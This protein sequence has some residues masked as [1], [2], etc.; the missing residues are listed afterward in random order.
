MPVAETTSL[1][2]ERFRQRAYELSGL[3]LTSYKAPQ[4]QRRLTALLARVQVSTFAEYA[5]LLER[6][7]RRLQEFR[8]FVTINVSEFFRDTDR[9]GEL[10]RRVLPELLAAAPIRGLSVWSAGCSIGAEPYSLA[11]LL[12]E[13]GP[14]RQHSVLATDIDQTVLERARAGRGYQAAELRNVPAERIA[15]WFGAEPNGC[16]TVGPVPRASVT[17][18]QHDLLRDPYPVEPFDLIACRNVVIYF[19]EAAKERIYE[20]FVGA[21]RPGGVLFVG[22]TEAILKPQALSLQALGP[23]FYRKVA[24]R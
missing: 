15:R 1:D 6:D 14:G 20:G 13:L 17:F 7:P 24:A 3:D 16:Y 19:T 8:D 9:F 23:G 4:M 11:I 18:A 2:F 22:G 21:L 5:V 10:E 12:R